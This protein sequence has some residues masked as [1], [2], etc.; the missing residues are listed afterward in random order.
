M[1]IEGTVFAKF[2]PNDISLK[3]TKLQQK[4]TL[5][6]PAIKIRCNW[7]LPST[8]PCS[9][10]WSA[11]VLLW[12]GKEWSGMRRGT[13]FPGSSRQPLPGREGGGEW[14]PGS[15]GFSWLSLPRWGQWNGHKLTRLFPGI[16]AAVREL[17]AFHRMLDHCQWYSLSQ[18]GQPSLG[19]ITLQVGC[20]QIWIPQLNPTNSVQLA[21]QA[22]HPRFIKLMISWTFTL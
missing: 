15:P 17:I 20:R 19:G 12:G 7:L 5:T 3:I 16:A 14:F 2:I 21:E 22:L 4:P 10:I 1:L 9:Q 11:T 13:W 6:G 18:R 8:Q